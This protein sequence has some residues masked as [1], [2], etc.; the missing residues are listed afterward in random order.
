MKLS[1]LTGRAPQLPLSLELEDGQ[2]LLIEQWLRVLP[3]QRYVARAQWQDRNV[4]VF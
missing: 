1:Q 3:E 2:A 4:L